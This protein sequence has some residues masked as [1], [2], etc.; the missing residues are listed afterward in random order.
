MSP[1]I[2]IGIDEVGRGCLFGEVAIGGFLIE[3]K[4]EKD[5]QKALKNF[6][7]I[8]NL[9][10]KDSKK[11][12]S[13]IREKYFHFLKEIQKKD[14]GDFCISFVSEKIIDKKGIVFALKIGVEKVLENLLKNFYKRFAEK[15]KNLNSKIKKKEINKNQNLNQKFKNRNFKNKIEDIFLKNNFQNIEI[16]LDGNLFANKKYKNQKTI[17]KGDEKE[18]LISLASIIAKE[19]RD[20]KYKK[21]AKNLKYKKYDIENNVGYGTPKHLTALKKYKPSD[22]H[23]I[24][25]LKNML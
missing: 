7:K 8:N 6:Q 19:S 13:K 2:K 5:F 14:L 18:Y 12:S 3:D 4:K 10:L 16:K 1:H 25:F 11:L 9:K 23:R 15:N 21:L 17:I 24:S 20:T 22:K